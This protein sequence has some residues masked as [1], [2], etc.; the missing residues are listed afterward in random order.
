MLCEARDGT[1]TDLSDEAVR[2]ALAVPV[3]E[4]VEQVAVAA[5]LDGLGV[6]DFLSMNCDALIAFRCKHEIPQAVMNRAWSELQYREV[7]R[8][9]RET[10]A[11]FAGL[12]G[13]AN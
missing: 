4:A 8:M 13:R 9:D 11:A 12:F 7:E 3:D 5:F 6:G 2:E 10:A 1:P